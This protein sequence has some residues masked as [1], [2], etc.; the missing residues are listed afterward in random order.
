M[1]TKKRA[2]SPA[3]TVHLLLAPLTGTS[4]AQQERLSDRQTKTENYSQTFSCTT[5][6]HIHKLTHTHMHLFPVVREFSEFI[7]SFICPSVSRASQ[8]GSLLLLLLHSLIQS[9]SKEATTLLL[10]YTTSHS[11]HLMHS[12]TH[13][14]HFFLI[15]FQTESDEKQKRHCRGTA[16]C[17]YIVAVGFLCLV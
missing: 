1:L 17:T 3:D 11:Y 5:H 15:L 7:R 13:K 8:P 2:L 6:K 9:K 4:T 16:P 14:I 10:L 12:A